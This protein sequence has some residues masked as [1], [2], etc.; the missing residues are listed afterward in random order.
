MLSRN[1]YRRFCNMDGDLNE[2]T[3]GD[4]IIAIERRLEQLEGKTVGNNNVSTSWAEGEIAMRDAY[5]DSLKA[6]IEEMRQDRT[7]NNPPQDEGDGGKTSNIIDNMAML[8]RRLVRQVKKH[9][10]GNP[11]A[12]AATT[13]LAACGLSGSPL[14]KDGK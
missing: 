14:R 8:I 13:Y 12:E 9:E 3:V 6:E 5:I 2:K 1:E 4:A 10:T 11:V 7:M